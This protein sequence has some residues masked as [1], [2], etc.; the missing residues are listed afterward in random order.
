METLL[1]RVVCAIN[2]RPLGVANKGYLTSELQAITPNHLLLGGACP[3]ASSLLDLDDSLLRKTAYVSKLA[4]AWWD[5]WT[6]QVG[7]IVA[8]KFPGLVVSDY[9]LAEVEK[10][11]QD[12]NEIAHTVMIKRRQKNQRENIN[13]FKPVMRIEMIGVPKAAELHEGHTQHLPV[14]AGGVPDGSILQGGIDQPY[15]GSS[16]KQ[17]PRST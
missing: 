9:Q 12:H 3:G 1:A 10:F 8:V 15:Q 16:Q 14:P 13:I 5:R 6:E 7:D 4:K 11:N 2:A 17:S